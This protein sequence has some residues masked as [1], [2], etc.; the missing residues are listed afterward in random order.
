MIVKDVMSK[1]VH[2][3]QPTA[4]LKEALKIMKEKNVKALVV[5]KQHPHDAYGIITYT[6]LLKAIYME[7]GDIDL[8][9]VYDV[10]VKP[11]ISISEEIDIKYAAKMMVNFNIKRLLVVEN[12]E[13]KGIISMTDIIE[14]LF[15]EIGE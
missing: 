3:V 4:S 6:S 12:N 15:K 5:D 11:A 13:I 8:L 1:E 14:S 7:E 10:A 9:N 2:L